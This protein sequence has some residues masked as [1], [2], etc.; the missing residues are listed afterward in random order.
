MGDVGFGASNS[1]VASDTPP[2]IV[3]ADVVTGKSGSER[4]TVPVYVNILHS[5]S[6]KFREKKRIF[7]ILGKNKLPDLEFF[8]F[9]SVLR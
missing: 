3:V 8:N 6:L 5:P 9:F 7:Q 1:S 2:P 4:Y